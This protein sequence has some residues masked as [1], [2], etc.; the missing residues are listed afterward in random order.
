MRTDYSADM[1]QEFHKV[2]VKR[3]YPTFDVQPL[4]Y[5]ANIFSPHDNGQD[6]MTYLSTEGI[7][8]ILAISYSESHPGPVVAGGAVFEYFQVPSNFLK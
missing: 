8:C 3:K 6:D 4:Q 7:H 1:L 5:Y 2:L